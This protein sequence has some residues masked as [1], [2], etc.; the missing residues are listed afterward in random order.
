VLIWAQFCKLVGHN[1]SHIN[2]LYR[3]YPG[4]ER[5]TVGTGIAFANTLFVKVS[6]LEF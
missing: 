4:D 1:I 3:Q 2:P 6:S 5:W